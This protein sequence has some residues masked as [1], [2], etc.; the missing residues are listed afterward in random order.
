LA[1]LGKTGMGKTTLLESLI[2]ADIAAG[3][4]LAVIDPH[5]DLAESVQQSVASAR[6]NDVIL[7]DAADAG[8]P[9]AFNPLACT[10]YR[11]RPLVAGAVL[12][13]FKKLYGESWGPRL[14]HFLRNTLFTLLDMPG[15]SLALVPRLRTDARFRE[16][17]VQRTSDP[18]V[19]EFWSREF[20]QLAPKLQAEATAPILNKVGQFLT[21][22]VLRHILGQPES[23]IQ[24]RQIM[25]E[26]KILL[27]NLSKGRLGDD[28]STLL[29]SFLITA[30]QLAAMSRADVPESRRTDFYLYVDELGCFATEAFAGILSEARK[31]RLNL[32][33]ANQYLAQLSESTLA[34]VFGNVGNLLV[35]QVGAQDAP[36]LAEQLGRPVEPSDLLMLPK[37]Q[38]YARLLIDGQPSRPFSMRTTAPTQRRLDPRRAEIIRRVSR[39]RYARP[40]GQIV[41][42]NA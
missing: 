28:A 33:V 30:V 2:T 40:V 6:T 27:V 8:H 1:I 24:L 12:S 14:E 41:A 25:D 11:H 19:R 10:D 29:G 34:A 15:A 9:V 13:T 20:A 36:T 5:G 26:R 18:V 31:Y 39:R 3:R 38:A 35:F 42:A 37:Y 16:Q 7:F 17:A 23:R 4:G 22:P 32:I 21:N